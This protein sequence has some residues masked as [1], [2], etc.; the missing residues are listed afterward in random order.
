MNILTNI[1]L[2]G[3]IIEKKNKCIFIGKNTFNKNMTIYL[4]DKN[5]NNMNLKS[6]KE[7]ILSMFNDNELGINKFNNIINGNQYF[8]IKNCIRI[9]DNSYNSIIDNNSIEI[10]NNNHLIINMDIKKISH[11]TYRSGTLFDLIN[12]KNNKF[13]YSISID[14]I[15]NIKNINNF[16]NIINNNIIINNSIKPFNLGIKELEF[17]QKLGNEPYKKHNM[18]SFEELK[19]FFRLNGYKNSLKTYFFEFYYKLEE[20]A[21]LID[22][23]IK[24]K[25]E[26]NQENYEYLKDIKNTII[27]YGLNNCPIHLNYKIK[28][29]KNYINDLND[30]ILNHLM[31]SLKFYFNNLNENDKLKYGYIDE[32]N[33]IV[34]HD[35]ILKKIYL[36]DL[37]YY[38][39][40]PKDK[41]DFKITKI[42]IYNNNG[43]KF[44]YNISRFGLSSIILDKLE[45]LLKD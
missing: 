7:I 21:T 13:D 15:N 24:F 37:I 1:I 20:E 16:F 25:N 42:Y 45:N 6:F 17:L 22:L 41:N 8:V 44:L 10:I 11:N 14:N 2:L 39:Q 3:K 40:I 23:F 32:N 5:K 33:N 38:I 9:N 43:K 28:I 4:L 19:K 34:F 12:N 27:R 35:K 36:K 18:K 31:Y 30:F 26:L 29:N